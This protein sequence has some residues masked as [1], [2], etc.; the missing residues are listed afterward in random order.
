M[1]P[2]DQITANND[3]TEFQLFLFCIIIY[4]FEVLTIRNGR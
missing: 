1:I 3:V 2:A 4:T